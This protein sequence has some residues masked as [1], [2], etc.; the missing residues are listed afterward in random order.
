MLYWFDVYFGIH[1]VM[2]RNS[3]NDAPVTHVTLCKGIVTDIHTCIK[4]PLG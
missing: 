4:L 1:N 2:V 3:W